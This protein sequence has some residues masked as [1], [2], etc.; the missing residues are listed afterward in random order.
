MYSLNC[1]FL[2]KK[3]LY[4]IKNIEDS[5][6]LNE[7][8]SLENQVKAVRLQEKLSEEIYQHE[9]NKLLEPMTDEFRNISQDIPKTITETSIKNSNVLENLNEKNLDLMN[10]K[11]M[12]APTLASSLVNLFKPENKS[13]FSFKK[14]PN[15]TRMK[16]I[17]INGGIP[18]SIYNKMLTFRDSNRS[19]KLDG[20]L[21][22]AM[23]NYDFNVRTSNPQDRKLIYEF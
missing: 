19:F 5:Q 7:L 3:K 17:L 9:R 18:V 15:S 4:P 22:E 14:Y 23:M 2:V 8:V 6:K 20:G 11:G 1:T 13:K 16:N 10:D 21:L 12:I